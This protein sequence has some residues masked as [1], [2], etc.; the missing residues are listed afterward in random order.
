M[1]KRT[2]WFLNFIGMFFFLVT[3]G[4]A[5]YWKWFRPKHQR[6]GATDDEVNRTLPGDDLLPNAQINVT[7]AVTIEATPAEIWPWLVQLGQGRGGFYSY[8]WIENAMGLDIHTAPH[9]LPEHQDLKVGDI[10]PLAPDGFG[11][12]VAILEP[13]RALVL[14]GDTRTPGKNAPPVKAG[15]FL[16]TS[17]GFYLFPQTDGATR[18]VERWRTDWTPTPVNEFVYRG[19]LEPAAFVMERKMLLTLKARA[20]SMRTFTASA[21]PTA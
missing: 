11:V 15:E 10:I 4:G 14:H 7:H 19:F 1:R 2:N 21:H 8:D 3:T 16:A 20:E 5:I 6:W 13:E 9:I 17:W 18:L 12:P